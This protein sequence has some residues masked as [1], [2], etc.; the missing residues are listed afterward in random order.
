MAN[1]ALTQIQLDSIIT[2]INA[3]EKLGVGY[4]KSESDALFT[5]SEEVSSL[6]TPADLTALIP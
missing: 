2:A 3:R 4:T 6:F 1:V 5:T